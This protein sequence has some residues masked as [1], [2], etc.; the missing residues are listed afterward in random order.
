MRHWVD[1]DIV[2]NLGKNIA[3]QSARAVKIREA[4]VMLGICENSVRRLIVRGKLR[5]VRVLRH[6]LIPISEIEKLLS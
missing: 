6:V 3:N 2:M 5:A 1:F 4:A